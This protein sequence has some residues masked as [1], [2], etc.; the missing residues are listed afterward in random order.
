MLEI[1][2]LDVILKDYNLTKTEA[3][4]MLNKKGCPV[5]PRVKRGAY[6]VVREEFEEWLR[7]QKVK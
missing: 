2:T 7:N 5:L 4:R 3:L 6:K 1:I